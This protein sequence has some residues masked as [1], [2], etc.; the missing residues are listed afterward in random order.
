MK[1]LTNMKTVPSYMNF[2]MSATYLM[3]S[4]NLIECIVSIYIWSVFDWDSA[5]AYL[6]Y[7]M[8]RILRVIVHQTVPEFVY[9]DV[10]YCLPYRRYMRCFFKP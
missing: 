10:R 3:K 8:S 1:Y 6:F 4:P 2:S 9:S 7:V 5:G